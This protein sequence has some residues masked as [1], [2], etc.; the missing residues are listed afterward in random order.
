MLVAGLPVFFSHVFSMFSRFFSLPEVKKPKTLKCLQKPK[1]PWMPTWTCL[2]KWRSRVAEPENQS[3]SVG[4]AEHTD[5]TFDCIIFDIYICAILS[6]RN[7]VR[8]LE[9]VTQMDPPAN[10]ACA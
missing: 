3:A 8:I 9:F 1:K 2:A 5:E 6:L 4:S 7:S 10:S